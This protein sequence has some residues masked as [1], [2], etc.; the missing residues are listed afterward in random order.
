MKLIYCHFYL[1]SNSGIRSSLNN[2]LF[3]G[4]GVTVLVR[5]TLHLLDRQVLYH[6]SHAP[7]PLS[8]IFPSLLLYFLTCLVARM[9]WKQMT[10]VGIKS[11]FLFIQ[12]LFVCFVTTLYTWGCL[13]GSFSLPPVQKP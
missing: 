3:W 10:L 9:A 7:S 13:A 12:L 5:G 4:A 8:Y 11:N 6:L 1:P 2:I